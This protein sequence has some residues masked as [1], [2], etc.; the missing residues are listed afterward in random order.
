M[1]EEEGVL[2]Y[3]TPAGGWGVGRAEAAMG[4]GASCAS[5]LSPGRV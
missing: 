4:R 2:G 5:I 1:V 3:E